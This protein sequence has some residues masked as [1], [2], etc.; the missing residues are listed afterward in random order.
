L[1]FPPPR[2]LA[3]LPPKGRSDTRLAALL[4]AFVEEMLKD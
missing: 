4:D 3:P 2:P 1:A